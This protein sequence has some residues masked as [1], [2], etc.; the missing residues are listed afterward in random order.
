MPG[1]TNRRFTVLLR[2]S[3][4]ADLNNL[5]GALEVDVVALTEIFVPR[6]YR[7]EMGMIDAPLSTIISGAPGESRS[8]AA[9]GYRSLRIC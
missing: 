1:G 5:L 6:G 2:N 4:P 8:T 7:A 9:Q 3:A